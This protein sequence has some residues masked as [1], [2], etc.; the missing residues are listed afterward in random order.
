[1]I[2]TL[3]INLRIMNKVDRALSEA[4]GAGIYQVGESKKT[5]GFLKFTK[6]GQEPVFQG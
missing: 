6:V 1:M 5:T 3:N 4:E 2:E